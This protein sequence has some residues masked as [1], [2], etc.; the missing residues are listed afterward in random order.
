MKRVIQLFCLVLIVSMVLAIPAFAAEQ[1]S[2]YFAA[3]S[4]YILEVSDSEFQ[5]WFH[6]TAVD[7]MDVLGVSE[8][9]VQYST[10][11]V[12]WSTVKTYSGQYAYNTGSHN[13]YVTYSSVTSS[14]YYRAK[15]TYYA[16]NDSGTAEY[17]NYTPFVSY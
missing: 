12:N 14:G 17:A 13:G 9:K 6:V 2:D 15:V 8:I 7:G 1:A 5:V 4:S 16:E 3:H 10:D 11:T